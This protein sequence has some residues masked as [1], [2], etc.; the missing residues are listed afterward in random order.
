MYKNTIPIHLYAQ[1][2]LSTKPKLAGAF[3]TSM[4]GL[5]FLFNSPPLFYDSDSFPPFTVL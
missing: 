5:I 3:S 1:D 4:L 2:L